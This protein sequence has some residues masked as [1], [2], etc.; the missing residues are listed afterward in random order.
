MADFYTDRSSPQ[1]AFVHRSCSSSVWV[2]KKTDLNR[3]WSK[4]AITRQTL[5]QPFAPA[6]ML[7]KDVPMRKVV[8]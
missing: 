1:S 2:Q 6:D 5:C 3:L 4:L 7:R 8:L